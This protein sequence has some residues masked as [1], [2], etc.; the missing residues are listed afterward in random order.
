MTY[1]AL[2]GGRLPREVDED[3]KQ[4]TRSFAQAARFIDAGKEVIVQ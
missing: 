2:R 4:T 1:D 3:S